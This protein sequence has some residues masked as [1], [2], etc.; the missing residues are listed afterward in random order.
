MDYTKLAIEKAKEGGYTKDH[1][2]F[3]DPEFWKCLLKT[4]NWPILSS[5]TSKEPW[6]YYYSVFWMFKDEFTEETRFQQFFL[7]NEKTNK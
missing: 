4:T 3:I 2:L 1:T 7:V 6:Q 5:S